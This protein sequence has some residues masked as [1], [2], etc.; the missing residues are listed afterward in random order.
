[1]GG[2]SFTVFKEVKW[3]N[4]YLLVRD[5]IMDYIKAKGTVD[6]TVEGR[7]TDVSKK[8]SLIEEFFA[9]FAA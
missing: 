1:M 8:T 3:T 7:I 6:P 5:A 9:L 2:D 4:T